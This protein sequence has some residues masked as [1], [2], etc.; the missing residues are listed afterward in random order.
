[1]RRATNQTKEFRNMAGQASSAAD[2][3]ARSSKATE[4]ALSSMGQTAT[5]SMGSVRA[6]TSSA[7][8][9]V[10]GLT[11]ALGAAVVSSKLLDATLGSAAQREMAVVTTNA[12]FKGDTAKADAYFKF[13][14]QRA[15]ESATLSQNDYFGTAKSFVAITKD[16]PKLQ[17]LT[18]LAERLA[19][20]DPAQGLS[21]AALALRELTSGDGVSLTE[22]FEMPRSAIN[23]IKDLPIEKQITALDKLL[24]QQ[25]FTNKLIADQGATAVGQYNQAVDKLRMGLQKMGVQGLERLKPSLEKF[26]RALD[27]EG[28]E[29][30]VQIGADAMYRFVDGTIRA[31]EWSYGAY[32]RFMDSLNSDEKFKQLSW[33]EKIEEVMNRAFNRLNSW[34]K[35][36]ETVQQISATGLDIGKSFGM[37]VGRGMLDGLQSF[38]KSDPVLAGVLA[39]L[40][41][42]GGIPVKVAVA[43]GVSAQG[44]TNKVTGTEIT[45]AERAERGITNP[46]YREGGIFNA[47]PALD[48]ISDMYEKTGA[49]KLFGIDGSHAGGLDRVP[50]DG[51]VAELHAGERVQTKAEADAYRSGNGGKGGGTTVNFTLHYSGQRMDEREVDWLMGMFVDKLGELTS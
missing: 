42:P 4:R 5:R 47:K 30:F 29:R 36:S 46:F 14:E 38:A 22:R 49:N 2:R 25:G 37:A 35:S 7:I 51:Y 8:N 45:A 26:N 33:P 21:G 15:A 13:L 39:G 1:M 34:L 18:G 27:G 10:M 3:F 12:M 28:F 16:L 19:A 24:D 20:S 17:K 31:F 48:Y 9:S 43:A 41:V 44:Y 40:A 23:A 32:T 11:T 50:Y 6:G